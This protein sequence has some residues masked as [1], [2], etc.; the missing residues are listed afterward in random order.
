MNK[1][2]ELILSRSIASLVA[3]GVY[4]ILAQ[5]IC[6][7]ASGLMNLA[8]YLKYLLQEGDSRM[9]IWWIDREHPRDIDHVVEIGL[10]SGFHLWLVS[11][12]GLIYL[13]QQWSVLWPWNWGARD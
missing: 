4:M 1:K 11:L 6:F 9:A 7:A 12:L 13:R 3:L 8:W 2:L 5:V 10:L